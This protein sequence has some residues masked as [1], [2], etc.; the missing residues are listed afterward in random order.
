MMG[1]H[2]IGGCADV[3]RCHSF[4]RGGEQ[5]SKASVGVVFASK[6]PTGQPLAAP[7]SQAASPRPHSADGGAAHTALTDPNDV[8]IVAPCGPD[9]EEEGAVAIVSSMLERFPRSPACLQAL[10]ICL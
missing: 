3:V 8:M 2:V 4:A 9:G 10:C 6:W 7:G 1:G 5:S